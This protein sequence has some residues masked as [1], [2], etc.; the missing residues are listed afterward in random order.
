M[1][2]ALVLLIGL[3]EVAGYRTFWR[4]GRGSPV[5][6][7][8]KLWI[9]AI[10]LGAAIGW[11]S[12]VWYSF[13]LK[14]DDPVTAW[15]LSA[16]R[17]AARLAPLPLLLFLLLTGLLT[18][19]E[20]PFRFSPTEV[21]FL[22]AGPFRR[23]E[24]VNF[25]LGAALSGQVL[26]SILVAPAGM[27]VSGPVAAFVGSLLLL[28]FVHLLTVVAGSLGATLGL[29]DPRG[30]RRLAIMMVFVCP[31][32]AVLW[33]RSGQSVDIENPIEV[34]RQVAGSPIAMAASSPL[35]CFVEV[36]LAN[37]L[38]PD[39]IVWSSL[40]L[41]M[42]GLLF[43]TVHVLDARLERRAQ[44]DDRR[45]ARE[46]P[47]RHVSQRVPWALPLFARC[48]GLG[49]IA[50]RQSISAFRRP[51][52]IS[53]AMLMYGILIFLLFVL[54]HG[55]TAI[56]FL[57]TLD[58]HREINPVGARVFGTF[59][60][61]LSMFIATGLSFDFRGDM[62]QIDVLK[63]LP[64][65]PLV[66]TAGQ[67]V[68]PV[69]VAAVMQ[70]LALA[71]MA[72][73]FGSVPAALWVAA[74]F[75]LPVSVVLM[76]IENLPTLWFPVRHTPGAKPEPFEVLG[77]V[78]VHPFLRLAGYSAAVVATSLVSAA[79]YFLFGQRASAALIAAWLTLAA[80]GIGLVVILADTFDRFD[81][82]RDVSG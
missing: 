31:A 68:V 1:S 55:S 65:E 71:V 20:K 57:P 6:L 54:A 17:D 13:N 81:V 58:G 60:I 46:D 8:G 26:I 12:G 69:M 64:I 10:L 52:Q 7:L 33:V 70:W 45:A 76:A 50:W 67:L 44:E 40:C 39:L 4:S 14:Q 61:V 18:L 78:L 27:V 25:K 56:L 62:G 9:L 42:N 43:A 3:R 36:V 41:L 75:V 5:A 77:R 51:Q 22:C 74:A 35:R 23:R 19:F 82:A 59:V 72:I 28:G 24:L 49:P 80:G 53:I 32:L 37:R 48:H 11:V 73:A 21:D 16:V 15:L 34:C 2:R 29:H 63:A 66:L 79:A 38:W 47:G 30:I